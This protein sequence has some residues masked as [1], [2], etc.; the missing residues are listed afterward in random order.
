[1]ADSIDIAQQREAENLARCLANAIHRPVG[2]SASFCITCDIPIQQA[3]RKALPG[4][5]TCV[6]CQTIQ[7]LK[8]AHFGKRQ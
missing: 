4:V 1:M 3:R 8:S 6:H 7:E 2:V 5:M